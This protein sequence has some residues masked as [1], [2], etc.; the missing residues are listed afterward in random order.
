[1]IRKREAGYYP[2]FGLAMIHVGLGHREE[3]LAWLDRAIGERNTGYFSMYCD[4]IYDS[5]RSEPR[6]QELLRKMK[7]AS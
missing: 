3:A 1:M 6:Y 4:P 7:H 5:L 2:A